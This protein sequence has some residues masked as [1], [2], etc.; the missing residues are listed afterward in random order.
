MGV[1]DPCPRPSQLPRSLRE[2]RLALRL[3]K[4]S[5][6]AER[7]S[8]FAD[9][10]VLRMLASVDDLA[11]VEAFV[12]KWLGALAAY[13]ERKH[14][15]LVKTLT[16]YLAAR[17]RLRGHLPGPVRAPQHAEVPA[18]ADPRADR[19]RAGRSRD[20]TSTCSWPPGP[21]LTLQALR[22]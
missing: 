10:D 3:Q 21:G 12:Q 5:S 6:A 1:G 14:T 4:A 2:A 16:Q 11:D 9:L 7:T 13:D 15:E 8:V 22:D 17:R 18:P 20:A 19:L